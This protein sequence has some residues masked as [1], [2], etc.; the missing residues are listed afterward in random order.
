MTYQSTWFLLEEY[1]KPF[2]RKSETELVH[3]AVIILPATDCIGEQ[4]QGTLLLD[5]AIPSDGRPGHFRDLPNGV[6]RNRHSRM[7]PHPLKE[8]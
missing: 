5:L 1:W 7:P 6:L 4:Y 8:E 2:Y 3:A